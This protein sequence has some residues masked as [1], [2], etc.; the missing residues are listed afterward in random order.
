MMN[1]YYV[2]FGAYGSIICGCEAAYAAFRKACDLS[3][4]M[5]DG[6][7]IVTLCDADTGEVIADNIED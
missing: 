1:F 4:L 6:E 3:D 2:S 5:S 7:I